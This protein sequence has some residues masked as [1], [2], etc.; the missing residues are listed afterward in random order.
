LVATDVV[1]K[2]V[3][4]GDLI[5]YQEIQLT[6][7]VDT[8]KNC[9][10]VSAYAL[11]TKDTGSDG[12]HGKRASGADRFKAN[13]FPLTHLKYLKTSGDSLFFAAEVQKSP[14]ENNFTSLCLERRYV[15]SIL[16]APRPHRPEGEG[17]EVGK[18]RKGRRG[19]SMRAG[20]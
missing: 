14:S 6:S 20:W 17:E 1:L 2:P 7:P 8:L 18:H 9:D 10:T 19:G 11:I 5:P 12:D 4:I 3:A 13:G 15:A 16:A